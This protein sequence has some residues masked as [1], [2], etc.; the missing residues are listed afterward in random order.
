[1]THSYRY[2]AT[3]AQMNRGGMSAE[4]FNAL[5]C[6]VSTYSVTNETHTF[7]THLTSGTVLNTVTLDGEVNIIGRTVDWTLP[8]TDII[9]GSQIVTSGSLVCTPSIDYSINYASGTITRLT[10][11]NILYGGTIAVDYQWNRP[12]IDPST[13]SPNRTCP[14]CGG[15]GYTWGSGTTIIGLPHIPKF[16]SPFMKLG[17]FQTGDMMFTVPEEYQISISYD[18][19]DPLLIRDKLI[20]NGEEWRVMSSPSSI[21]LNNEVL[22]KQLHCRRKKTALN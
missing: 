14:Q 18:G 4:Y 6:N 7:S 11:G 16:D 10:T 3:K 5:P 9:S 21:Q 22:A 2:N 20:V 19:D 8:N 15:N 13:G 17:Y 1:M 12:C